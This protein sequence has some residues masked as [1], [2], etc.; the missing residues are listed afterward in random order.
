MSER[1]CGA[2]DRQDGTVHATSSPL[3][4][5]PAVLGAWAG[6]RVVAFLLGVAFPLAFVAWLVAV[7]QMLPLATVAVWAVQGIV[8]TFGFPFLAGDFQMTLTPTLLTAVVAL[9]IARAASHLRDDEMSE[10]GRAWSVLGLSGVVAVAVA[11]MVVVTNTP[12]SWLAVLKAAI[13]IVGVPVWGLRVGSEPLAR[14]CDDRLSFAWGDA[15]DASVRVARRVWIALI[16]AAHVVLAVAVVTGFDGGMQVV[17]GYSAPVVAAVGLGALQAMFALTIWAIALSWVTGLWAMVGGGHTISAFQPTNAPMPAIPIFGVIPAEA[18]PGAVALVAVPIVAVALAV[19]LYSRGSVAVATWAGVRVVVL[20][21]C[22]SPFFFG[23]MGPG[24]LRSVGVQ[25]W[26]VCVAALVW[27]GAGTLIG[28][29]MIAL[30]D[31]Y[32]RRAAAG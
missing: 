14:L 9:R 17:A 18:H 5:H 8:A 22:A 30:R 6:V 3:T 27:V 4:S 21:V 25:P 31:Y 32:D 23:A 2:K 7:T 11:L 15:V 16:V 26:V 1:V 20:A 24:G 10:A 28:V 12:V 29:G 13:V 19:A